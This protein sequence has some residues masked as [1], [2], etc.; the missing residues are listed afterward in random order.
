MKQT[1]L[2]IRIKCHERDYRL[3]N[4]KKTIPLIINWFYI[5]LWFDISKK[6]EDNL[7]D[8]ILFLPLLMLFYLFILF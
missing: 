1:V 7:H 8:R 2:K 6:K 5:N 3:K 4:Y